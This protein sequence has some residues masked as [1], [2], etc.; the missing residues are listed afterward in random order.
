VGGKIF[1]FCCIID[2]HCNHLSP[3][4]VMIATALSGGVQ[5][6]VKKNKVA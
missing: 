3:V 1:W 5:S 6:G 2:M 4:R